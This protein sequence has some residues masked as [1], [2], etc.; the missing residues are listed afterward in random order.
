[1]MGIAVSLPVVDQGAYV[2]VPP[3]LNCV[4][5]TDVKYQIFGGGKPPVIPHWNI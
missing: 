3:S 4:K 2:E 1:M 5:Y